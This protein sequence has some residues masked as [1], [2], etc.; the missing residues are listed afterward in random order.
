MVDR[1]SKY[2]HFVPIRHSISAKELAEK[3][4]DYICKYHGL[5]KVIV[6]DRD[7]LFT[8][9]F[10][11][12]IFKLMG[13]KLHQSTA[14]HPQSNG[15][16][17]IVNKSLETYLRC[18]SSAFPKQWPKWLPMAEYWYNTTYHTS[19]RMCP[20]QVLYGYQPPRLLHYVASKEH[21]IDVRKE[22]QKREE[23]MQ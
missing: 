14:Y 12:E 4:T 13:T 6:S 8:N 16:T 19:T 20:F 5:P 18:Y 11:K 1:L 22:L 9:K 7:P 23:I 2:N 15:Q 21:N 3:F 17:E 10:W